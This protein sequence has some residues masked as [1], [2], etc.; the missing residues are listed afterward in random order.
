[1]AAHRVSG[2]GAFGGAGFYFDLGSIETKNSKDE[3]RKINHRGTLIEGRA[4]SD[5]ELNPGA[6]RPGFRE[7]VVFAV[8]GSTCGVRCR[9]AP[10]YL[11]LR[12]VRTKV[13]GS[14]AR[15]TVIAG[16]DPATHAAAAGGGLPD[17]VRQ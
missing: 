9:I 2:L 16:L 11:R 7:L 8:F 14:S 3:K 4:N 15:L 12:R 13:E 17:Q 6:A 1:M 5:E 10:Q